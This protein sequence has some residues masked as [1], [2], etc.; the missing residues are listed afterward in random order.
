MKEKTKRILSVAMCAAV[1]VTACCSL[2]GCTNKVDALVLMSEEVD[3]LFNPFYATTG[4][5]MEIVGMTQI[6]ML[7]SGYE[8]VDGK[9][10]ATVAYGDNEA[11]VVKDYSI[12]KIP[13]A[14]AKDDKTKYTFILKNGITFSDGKPLTMNDVLFNMYVYLDPVYTGSTTMYSTDIVGLEQYRTQSTNA[15]QDIQIAQTASSMASTR[16]MELRN[17]YIEKNALLGNTDTDPHVTEEQMR[18]A[19]LSE[20]N[21]SSGYKAA[22]SNNPSEVTSAQLLADFELTLK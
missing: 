21:L 2:A 19:I 15:N 7:T 4:A 13:G 12:D 11:V 3:G 10:T 1:G 18:Q 16:I 22:I 20:H 14:T 5:D 8:V 9:E 6:S 17:T